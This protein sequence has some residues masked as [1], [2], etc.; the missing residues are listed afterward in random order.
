MYNLK[1]C[2][3]LFYLITQNEENGFIVQLDERDMLINLDELLKTFREKIYEHIKD[4]VN[5]ALI[6]TSRE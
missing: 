3:K 5:Y 6:C 1:K 2:F 4:M